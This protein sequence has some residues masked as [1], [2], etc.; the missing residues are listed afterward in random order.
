MVGRSLSVQTA[1]DCRDPELTR[2]F[3]EAVVKA[4]QEKVSELQ[5]VP[6]L[7]PKC[8]DDDI[9]TESVAAMLFVVSHA[10]TLMAGMS[11]FSYDVKSMSKSC[12]QVSGQQYDETRRLQSILP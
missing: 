10:L 6:E 3:C 2:A 4:Q 12:S 11:L 9:P 7:G 8:Q 5:L 1:K